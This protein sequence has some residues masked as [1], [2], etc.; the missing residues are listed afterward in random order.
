M[1]RDI[2]GP[3]DEDDD[4]NLSE[5]VEFEDDFSFEDDVDSDDDE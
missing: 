4:D 2:L 5:S 1:S 3:R